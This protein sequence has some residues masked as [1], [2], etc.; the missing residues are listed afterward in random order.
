[1]DALDHEKRLSLAAEAEQAKN[2][3]DSLIIAA[4]ALAVAVVVGTAQS[5]ELISIYHS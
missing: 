4:S 3:K 1:M 5:L 2:R